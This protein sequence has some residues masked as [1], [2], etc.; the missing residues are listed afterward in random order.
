[1]LAIADFIQS[2]SIQIS[3]KWISNGPYACPTCTFQGFLLNMADVASALCAGAICVYTVLIGVCRFSI[4]HF[5]SIA[6][7][8][9]FGFPFIIS[10]VGLILGHARRPFYTP[11]GLWCWID[12]SYG[13]YRIGFHYLWIFLTL[14]VMLC[15]YGLMLWRL[16]L[17]IELAK[18]VNSKKQK[19]ELKK[20]KAILLNMIWYP[21]V[22]AF[23]FMP[24]A[25]ERMLVFAGYSTSFKFTVYGACLYCLNGTFN[26]IVYGLT[27]RLHKR[28]SIWITNGSSD[29]TK[30]IE[31]MSEDPLEF[32]TMS[33]SMK[34][35]ESSS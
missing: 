15:L 29:G 27:R 22:Y 18:H 1:M 20:S 19:Q 30:S 16:R 21:M 28:F 13:S 24:L 7:T 3:Y 32:T 9:C 31:V 35:S 23:V 25:I 8:I 5:V 34:A 14:F 10:I 6:A 33:P 12:A 26:F 4:P 2:I 17:S 11:V